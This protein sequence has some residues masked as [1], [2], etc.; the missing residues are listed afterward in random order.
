MYYNLGCSLLVTYP[1]E[2]FAHMRKESYIRIF[3]EVLLIRKKLEIAS[4][5]L[6][7]LSIVISGLLY[8]SENE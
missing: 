5:C 6:N 1:T 3:V 4:D 8:S 2:I 7:K